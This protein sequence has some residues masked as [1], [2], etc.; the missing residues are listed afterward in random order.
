MI[1]IKRHLILLLLYCFL[2]VWIIGLYQGVPGFQRTVKQTITKS[3]FIIQ[4]QIRQF[5]GKKVISSRPRIKEKA[6]PQTETKGAVT[7]TR[8]PH[9]SAT[10]YVNVTNQSLH[11]ATQ[12][13]IQQWNHTKAFTFRQISNK[14]K[15]NI[16]V[17]TISETKNSAAGL[18]IINMNETTGYLVHANIQLNTAYLLDPGISSDQV[19]NTVEHELGHA[20]GLQ[21]TN[22]ISVMQPAG[23][24]Y[25]IQSLDVQN[26]KRLYAHRPQP[27]KQSGERNNSQQSYH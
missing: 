4:N 24:Q 19:L 3:R 9:A 1:A 26:V 2:F 8:W 5:Q 13:A 20:I 16:V 10:I 14:Q 17:S 25:S 27:N 23:A 21:H 18:T 15:A 7:D 12:Q 22:A 11:H 6:T